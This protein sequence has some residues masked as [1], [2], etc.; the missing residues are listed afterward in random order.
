MPKAAPT[1]P[2]IIA[3]ANN[4]GGVGK[5]TTTINL[6]GALVLREKRVLVIDLD[7]Q[8]NASIALDVV[9]S[10]DSLGTKLLLQDETHAVQDCTYDKGPYLDIVPAQRTLVDIQH[11]LLI[12]PAGRTRLRDKLK[13]GG[14]SYDYVL[15]DCPPDV[16]SLT[17]S[18]LVAASDVLIPVDVGYFSIDGLDNMLDLLA[19]VQKAFNPDLRLLGILVTKYDART[20]LSS[21]T[22][23]SIQEENL[24]LL[25]PPIRVCVEVIRAQMERAPVS[26]VSPDSSAAADYE[27]LAE[28]L[29]PARERTARTKPPGRKVVQLRRQQPK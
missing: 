7:P 6:A 13:T 5:T 17:Q 1:R 10:P 11:P 3:I 21:N 25:A 4:K 23:A 14:K 26:I 22:L 8:A 2:R 9:I 20:T 28:T 12:N 18:A 24:P 19:Q 15:L 27:A 29:L 16:G